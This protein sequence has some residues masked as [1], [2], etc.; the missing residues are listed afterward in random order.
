M[1]VALGLFSAFFLGFYDVV[2]KK[3]LTNNAIIPVLFLASSTC[4]LIFVPF[5]IL[6]HFGI[7][8]PGAILY[9]PPVTPAMHAMFFLKSV[10]VGLS[11]FFGYFA[12]SNLPLTIVTPINS[13]GPLWTLIGALIIFG[14]R[15]S[16]FQ[17]IGIIV[18]LFFF[19]IFSLAGKHEGIVFSKNKWIY[20]VVA[21]T[22]LGA[23]SSLYDKYLFR[24]YDRIAVQAWYSIYFVPVFLPFV[25]LIWYPK[26]KKTPPFLWSRLIPIIGLALV[27]SD[28]LYFYALSEKDSLIAVLSVVRRSSV[29]VSFTAGAIFFSEQNLKRKSIALAGI[30]IGVISIIIGSMKF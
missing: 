2:R 17:W 28:F 11:W 10:I 23:V 24:N 27:I 6:S 19:Y 18:V 16:G 1:W 7:I 25:L 30:F 26:R 12:L 22:M 9:I 3:V 29:I 13:T 8:P 5:V 20:A 15:F 14:E 4:G 21:G